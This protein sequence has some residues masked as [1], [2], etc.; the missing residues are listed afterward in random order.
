MKNKRASGVFLHITSLPSKFGIGE[1]GSQAYQFAELLAQAGQSYWQVLPLCPT[2]RIHHYSPYSSLSAFAGNSLLIS[3][4]LL[5]RDGFLAGKELQNIPQFPEGRIDYYH[6][7]QHKTKLFD[8]AFE[9]FKSKPK[10]PD[11]LSF[12]SENAGWLDD[13][14]IF[15]A[16]RKLFQFKAWCDWP[17]DLKNRKSKALESVK[18]K[19]R[20]R[21]E[22]E[23]FLQYIFFRQWFSLKNYC[24]RRGI[25]II[26]DV[27]IYVA[28]DSADV[29]AHPE[30]FKL[31][32]EKKRRFVSA[33]VPDYFSRTG[34]IWG[35]PVYDWRELKRKG[36]YWWIQRI[37]HNLFLFDMVRIDHFRGFVAYWQVR[38]GAKTAANGKW[39]KGPAENFFKEL[40]KHFRRSRFIVEDLGHIT[41]RVREYIKKYRL[42]CT[43]VLLFAFDGDSAKNPH[44]PENHVKNCVVYTSTHDSNTVRGWFDNEAKPQQKKKL[45][46]YLGHKAAADKIHL[47]FIRLASSSAAEIVI[48]PVQDLLGLGQQGRM[49]RPATNR[50]NWSWKLKFG[51]ITPTATEELAKLTV[52]HGRD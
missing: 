17:K 10:K 35:H 45:F 27:P 11:Y 2:A 46:D 47:E 43:R 18:E 38:A 34:Q 6:V 33:T 5:Y 22:R 12:C 29:W 24:N 52:I 26:G 14:A 50:G 48:I 7:V 44:L 16:L 9:R 30:I 42:R 31:T 28:Y 19:L 36:Y 23:K 41:P 49:N 37:R 25:R 51:Q 15:S 32:A 39:V 21:I 3:G 20:D 40:F 4:E 13:F 1:L 8:S